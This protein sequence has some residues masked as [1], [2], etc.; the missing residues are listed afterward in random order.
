MLSSVC[1]WRPKVNTSSH[2]SGSTP[3]QA[4]K[5]NI[6]GDASLKASRTLP[7]CSGWPWVQIC[8]ITPL[9]PKKHVLLQYV[10]NLLLATDNPTK[11]W[12]A[13]QE[14][15]ELLNEKG[16]K[17]SWEK[18]Q[19]CQKQVKYLGYHLTQGQRE[20]G[21]GR[22]EAV[23]ALPEPTTRKKLRGFLRSSRVLL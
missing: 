2:S 6:H 4:E 13:T 19:L 17:V 5:H 21:Q 16:Y 7:R 3:K 10:D 14:L 12:E 22:K 9:Y 18:A 1:A 20:L 8:K 15:Q 11:C 23:C